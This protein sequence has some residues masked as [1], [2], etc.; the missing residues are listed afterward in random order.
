MSQKIVRK[1]TDNEYRNFVLKLLNEDQN[2]LAS[3]LAEFEDV[4]KTYFYEPVNERYIE[5]ELDMEVKELRTSL[6]VNVYE[7]YIN[8][9]FRLLHSELQSDQIYQTIVDEIKEL[10]QNNSVTYD[11]NFLGRLVEYFENNPL[12]DF[13]STDNINNLFSEFK[14]TEEILLKIES[15]L[16]KIQIYKELYLDK[17]DILNQVVINHSFSQNAN[18]SVYLDSWMEMK[19]LY[20]KKSD[21]LKVG[22]KFET[23]KFLKEYTNIFKPINLDKDVV[24]IGEKLSNHKIQDISTGQLIPLVN[25]ANLN[26][27]SEGLRSL[28]SNHLVTQYIEY[29]LKRLALTEPNLDFENSKL[30]GYLEKIKQNTTNH[31]FEISTKVFSEIYGDKFINESLFAKEELDSPNQLL[32]KLKPVILHDTYSFYELH[33]LEP[34]SKKDYELIRFWEDKSIKLLEDSLSHKAQGQ[35]MIRDFREHFIS[36]DGLQK[37]LRNV[38]ELSS[39]GDDISKRILN[40]IK[41]N[42]E[43]AKETMIGL[44]KE[45]QVDLV[46]N[47]EDKHFSNKNYNNLLLLNRAQRDIESAEI[48]TDLMVSEKS[49]ESQKEYEQEL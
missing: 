22:I 42:L 17:E 24:S 10:N 32:E 48:Y 30:N 26:E 23:E 35:G 25:Q 20:E 4:I 34:S 12:K 31:I 49:K 5:V 6:Q 37:L 27:K 41:D 1:L 38:D 8:N 11:Y 16:D 18:V 14:K 13:A 3:K 33:Q 46:L 43:T 2:Q 39:K 9:N 40:G 36:T 28:L 45:I 29:S 15:V 47:K 44:K 19:D 7:N 21:F